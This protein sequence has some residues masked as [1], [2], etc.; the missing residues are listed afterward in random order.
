MRVCVGG[1]VG[2]GLR[3]GGWG[4]RVYIRTVRVRGQF[5]MWFF[6]LGR[7]VVFCRF[8]VIHFRGTRVKPARLLPLGSPFEK[9]QSEQT[10]TRTTASVPSLP[11]PRSSARATGLSHERVSSTHAPRSSRTTTP[12][13]TESTPPQRTM[14]TAATARSFPAAALETPPAREV[15]SQSGREPREP[16]CELG[17]E[18]SQQA[19]VK[20]AL[21]T[22]HHTS[23]SV[24]KIR[25]RVDNAEG[26]AWRLGVE[27]AVGSLLEPT[28]EDCRLEADEDADARMDEVREPST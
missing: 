16:L 7:G 28:T 24:H 21:P 18:G 13:T 9:R 12:S 15:C 23:C 27:P 19:G 8:I 2:G 20:R 3:V 6:W 22:S 4:S 26:L 17:K 1:W 10:P 11:P 5:R 14:A 25:L